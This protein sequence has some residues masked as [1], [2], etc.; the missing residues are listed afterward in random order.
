ML[1]CCSVGR[2]IGKA[3]S[4]IAQVRS[5]FQEALTALKEYPFSMSQGNILGSALGVSCKVMHDLIASF[6]PLINTI[7]TLDRRK[8]LKHIVDSGSLESD[9]AAI[10]LP[11]E[12]STPQNPKPQPPRGRRRPPPQNAAPYHIPYHPSYSAYAGAY[13]PI[14]VSQYPHNTFRPSYSSYG[15]GPTYLNYGSPSPALHPAQ[16]PHGSSEDVHRAKRQRI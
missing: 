11:P 1:T 2:D 7:Q 13:A 12:W 9:L 8:H 10:V 15:P 16:I 6:H 4:R 14:P 5:A 3:T